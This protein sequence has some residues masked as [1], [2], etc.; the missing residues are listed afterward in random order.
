MSILSRNCIDAI[1]KAA[2]ANPGVQINIG[3]VIK[4]AGIV[5]ANPYC[6]VQDAINELEAE[7]IFVKKQGRI[8]YVLDNSKITCENSI[9]NFAKESWP[10]NENTLEN[11]KVEKRPYEK[12][13]I[14]PAIDVEMSGKAADK[15]VGEIK[16][17]DMP[18]K[19]DSQAALHFAEFEISDVKVLTALLENFSNVIPEKSKV[20]VS[21]RV[22]ASY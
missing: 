19:N 15:F 9:K 4:S 18:K 3:N 8:W 5:I 17:S 11:L 13:V 20:V 21:L 22:R 16:K 1:K 12:P 2:L 14:S 7:G 10:E 6:Y